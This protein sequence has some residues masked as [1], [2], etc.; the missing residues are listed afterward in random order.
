[1]QERLEKDCLLGIWKIEEDENFFI[2]HF[3]V[4]EQRLATI[5]N[6]EKRLEFLA[7]RYVAALLSD[8][9]NEALVL[10]KEN[11][12]PYFANLNYSLSISHCKGY[13]AVLL[14]KKGK[15]VGLDIEL[16]S[17]KIARIAERFIDAKE[18]PPKYLMNEVLA[19][20]LCWS[21]KESVF[22]C[23]D[24]PG[25]TFKSELIIQTWQEQS[26]TVAIDHSLLKQTAT[27]S[28]RVVNDTVGL[29]LAYTVQ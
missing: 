18:L 23:F 25:I 3:P 7:S 19:Q 26:A 22:K 27:V 5:S 14:N 16:C 13:A 28:Y 24:I 4:D 17:D 12:A 11:R 9:P 10:N 21:I 8:V 1:M 29:V 6:P 20:T 2:G 15:A